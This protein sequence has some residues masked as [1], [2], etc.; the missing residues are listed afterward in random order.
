MFNSL[1]NTK[2]FIDTNIL[3]YSIDIRYPDKQKIA[4]QLLSDLK[5]NNQLVVS[6]QVL[7]EFFVVATRKLKQQPSYIQNIILSFNNIEVVGSDFDLVT[8][9]ISI[10]ITE[11]LSMWDAL[12]IAG[13]KRANCAVMYSEDL[14]HGQKYQG[15][16]VQNPFLSL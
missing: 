1:S 12:V 2:I 9:A 10:S 6:T 8:D 7:Q 11:P 16:L 14:N 4:R 13:A 3:V 5:S 15:V